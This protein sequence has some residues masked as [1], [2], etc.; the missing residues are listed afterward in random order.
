M[1]VCMRRE[2]VGVWGC[3]GVWGSVWMY[4]GVRVGMLGKA[5]YQQQGRGVPTI[6]GGGG[7]GGCRDPPKKLTRQTS[8]RLS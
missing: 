3:E 7:G 2:C 8:A 1:C 4:I 6:F 5:I